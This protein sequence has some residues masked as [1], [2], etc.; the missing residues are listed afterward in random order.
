MFFEVPAPYSLLL[1]LSAN[2]LL[3]SVRF[4]VSLTVVKKVSTSLVGFG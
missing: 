1:P 4:V 2:V 3:P